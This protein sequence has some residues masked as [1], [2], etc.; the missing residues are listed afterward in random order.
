[1]TGVAASKGLKFD[2]G[3][4]V[5]D[6]W[7]ACWLLPGWLAGWLM[8]GWPL[9]AGLG[10]LAWLACCVAEW[11]ACWQK[12]GADGFKTGFGYAPGMRQTSKRYAPISGTENDIQTGPA[13]HTKVI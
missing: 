6:C 4:R 13:K 1:M 3:R 7:P 9:G 10:F 8:A 12:C 5:L 11:L 2:R